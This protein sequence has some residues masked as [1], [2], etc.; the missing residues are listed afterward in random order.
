VDFALT[1]LQSNVRREARTI[2]ARFSL[3]YWREHDQLERYPWGFVRA[4]ADAGWLG[5]LIPEAYGGAGLGLTEASLLLQAIG[6]SGAGTSGASAI[7]FYV[8]P[9]TPIVHHG[10]EYLKQTY[11]PRAARGELLVA[12]GVTEPSA[13]SDTS[14]IST[15]AT[16]EDGHWLIRGQ[17]VWT[18]NAQH[19]ERILLL[20][21]TSPRDDARPLEGLTLFFTELNRQTCTVRKLDKLGRAA[22]DSNEV[23]IDGLVAT[24]DEVVG[25]VGRG[26]YHLL[27]GLNPE[28]I[29]IA[30]EAVGI[31]QWAVEYAAEYASQRRVF[32]RPI[33]QNQAIAHPLADVW[34]ELQAAELLAYKAAW[35][36]DHGQSCG[37]EANAAK[38][39][40]AR[41]GFRAC[42]VALQT[43][44]GFGYA[45]DT[46]IERLWREV[47]LYEIA[48]ITQEMVL[49]Y[50]AEHVLH[51]P[52]SY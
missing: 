22:V 18:T 36:F 43:F 44:G 48:P 2:A 35:L 39:L 33:G 19:A 12:F 8:F 34:A 30:L 20:A 11:L 5:V 10:S 41:A 27:D 24:D 7:H 45:R 4:Y 32:D 16:R 6:Q 13:G 15:V 26:F 42:D 9:L 1:E 17:K 29:V 46:H 28:R 51:L 47:R 52:K 31:G 21:R 49:N 14:R 38:L 50:L 37:A 23:F 25:E 40:G 3:D